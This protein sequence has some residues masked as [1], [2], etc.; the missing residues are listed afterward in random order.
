MKPHRF[1]IALS[2]DGQP[3]PIEERRGRRLLRLIDPQSEEGRTLISSAPV[4]WVGPD[5]SSL[6]RVSARTAYSALL[7]RLEDRLDA[8]LSDGERR[9]LNKGLDRL[10]D[11]SR[12]LAGGAG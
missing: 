6:G 1:R 11:W 5:G 3:G 8:T 10:R 9:E 2:G 7:R 12:T 4:E